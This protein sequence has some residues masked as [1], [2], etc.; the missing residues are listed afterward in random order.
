MKINV[1]TLFSGYDSQC[2]ALERLKKNFPDF[3]YELIAWSEIDKYAIQAHNALFPQWAD[4]N[5]GDITKIDWSEVKGDIDLMTYSSPCFVAGTKVLT[6]TGY[7]NIEDIR[8]GDEAFT[9]SHT[10]KPITAIG[11][12]GAKPI[13]EVRSMGALPIRC[14]SN[15]PFLIRRKIR[16]WDNAERRWT[17]EF[18]NPCKCKVEEFVGGEYIG[19]P[20]LPTLHKP[21]YNIGCLFCPMARKSEMRMCKYRYPKYKE[22][23]IRTI[24]HIR[25]SDDGKRM[26]ADQYPYLTDEQVFEWWT[27]KMG[28]KE[29]VA[30][31][32]WQ[33]KLEL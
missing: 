19:V 28:I 15:H 31:N 2:L 4:R 6:S 3:D 10:F 12:D 29:W 30:K 11:S 7:K 9:H 1:A 8:I 18:T 17:Y 26:Y 22:A 20:I 25:T 32:I 14:T 24:H 5:L 21:A 13:W 27:S 33:G 16:K 23:I